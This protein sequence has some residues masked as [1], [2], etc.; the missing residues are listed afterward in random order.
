MSRLAR[1]TWPCSPGPF[2]RRLLAGVAPGECSTVREPRHA[3]PD[4]APKSKTP[5]LA[6]LTCLLLGAALCGCS[7]VQ[8]V[9][10]P[11][12]A[13]LLAAG[14][15]E[16]GDAAS[17]PSAQDAAESDEPRSPARDTDPDVLARRMSE[18]IRDDDVGTV[19]Q[20]L[21]S[22][23]IE[24]FGSALHAAARFESPRAAALLIERGADVNSD[25]GWTQLHFAL[26]D[27][28][29]RP[30]LQVANLLLEHGADVHAATS[31]MGW[32]PLH[33][34]AHLSGSDRVR[35][36]DV[37][38]IV[39]TLMER[40]AD[41]NARTRVG[42]WTP[43]RVAGESGGSADVLAAL[44]FAG[45][46]DDG[47]DD[48]PMVPA[49]RGGSRGRRMEWE[50]RRAEGTSECDMPF[51][52]PGVV[53]AG[54]WRGGAG[55]FTAPGADE[56]LLI[57]S[58]GFFEGRHTKLAALRDRHG[59]IRPIM[60]F[61]GYTDI[62]GLCFDAETATHTAVFTR[63]FDGCCLPVDTAYYHYDAD[64][65][66]LAEVFVDEG[67]QHS[68]A[69]ADEA[70][71]W[72]DKMAG[73]DVYEDALNA[74]RVGSL[75]ALVATGDNALDALRTALWAGLV[76][77]AEG[78]LHPLASRVVPTEVVETQLERLRKLSDIARVWSPDVESP[79]WKVVAA[80]YLGVVRRESLDAC[81]GVLLVWDGARQEWHSIYDCAE[82]FAIEI[83]GDTLS[84]ALYVGASDCGTRLR[85]LS[86]YL[87]VDLA[88]RQAR[89]WDE[90][91][92]RF[93]HERRERP[94]R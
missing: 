72:R 37:L 9:P 77:V 82:I 91:H 10:R 49:Y 5:R 64:A 57:E 92:G 16:A 27:G 89:L 52:V 88:T 11:A 90:P 41:V 26:L 29:D 51:A 1:Q 39:R 40:G 23:G 45:G 32:T 66:T 50:Q 2:A 19:R 71:R 55:S 25:G 12:D 34:A 48:A 54:S 73:L 61:D 24:S 33:F 79:R 42:G 4:E 53:D 15:N 63:G 62:Q 70:C 18:A 86:C 75:P 6:G 56:A 47:C 81:K 36:T 46:R 30:A 17:R 14:P 65:G 13:D 85:E 58:V 94:D 67:E 80:E 87:E 59:A 31:A 84:A 68:P 69:S 60:T 22:A 20:L 43:V 3:A 7:T 76:L 44:R 93:W 83:H 8:E 35:G 21:D 74:L 28:T 38:R 78:A